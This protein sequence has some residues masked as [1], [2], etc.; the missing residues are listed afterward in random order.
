MKRGEIWWASLGEPT[1]SE[2]G[3]KRPVVIVSSNDFNASKIKTIIVAV[4]TSNLRLSE[5]PGNIELPKKGTGLTR[6]S[7][8]NVSQLI[9]LDK[10]FLTE[11]IGKLP[12]KKLQLLNDGVRLVL[13]V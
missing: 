8:I 12:S 11:K 3:F 1:G 4:I 5:A 9:T 13:S 10:L 7:V 6:S 2:P